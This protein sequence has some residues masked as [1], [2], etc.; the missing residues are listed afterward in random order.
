MYRQLAIGIT[1]KHVREVYTPI[2]QYDDKSPTADKNAVFAMQSGHKIIQR[3]K[4]YGLDGVYPHRLQP[5][6]ASCYE[7]ASTRWHEFIHQASKMREEPDV[8]TSP[9]T[10]ITSTGVEKH[11]MFNG[12]K[13]TSTDVRESEQY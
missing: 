5:I 4:T 1:E 11:A 9:T 12:G 2:N 10:V 8:A 7:W 6:T 13:S 3:N